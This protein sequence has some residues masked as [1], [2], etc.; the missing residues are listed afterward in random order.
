MPLKTFWG[1]NLTRNSNT[2]S[3]TGQE[4]AEIHLAGCDHTLESLH[5]TALERSSLQFRQPAGAPHAPACP[6][7]GLTLGDYDGGLFGG[8]FPPVKHFPRPDKD[9]RTSRRHAV[10]SN[11]KV[12]D[13]AVPSLRGGQH[14][15]D[16]EVLG[17][18]DPRAARPSGE[19]KHSRTRSTRDAQLELR[20]ATGV[21]RNDRAHWIRVESG[22]L[23]R[24][25]PEFQSLV[26]ERRIHLD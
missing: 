14:P 25:H 18:R 26:G 10:P 20:H 8:I 1:L 9:P 5:P 11:I 15:K 24:S 19:H 4:L 12:G 21:G 23:R 6:I 16:R 7:S 3:Q 17:E 2:E 13:V 22:P